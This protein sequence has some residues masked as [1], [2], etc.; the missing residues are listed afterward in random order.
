M[1]TQFRWLL[2]WNPLPGTLQAGNGLFRNKNATYVRVCEAKRTPNI[3]K[4]FPRCRYNSVYSKIHA[5][6][7]SPSCSLLSIGIP[8]AENCHPHQTHPVTASWS[9]HHV[10]SLPL[11]GQADVCTPKNRLTGWRTQGLLWSPTKSRGCFRLALTALGHP[12]QA[13]TTEAEHQPRE[14]RG[15]SA[16]R[17]QR[18]TAGSFQKHL[19]WVLFPDRYKGAQAWSQKITVE[20]LDLAKHLMYS[21]GFQHTSSSYFKL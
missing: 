13:S 8:V 4:A 12:E 2:K 20:A 3:S 18:C 10:T 9:H 15:S 7:Q 14:L 21:L 16:S 1:G 17:A 11:H 19:G 6:S 5:K